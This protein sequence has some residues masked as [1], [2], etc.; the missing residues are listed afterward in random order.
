M[1]Y[2]TGWD[3]LGRGKSIAY[4]LQQARLPIADYENCKNGKLLSIIMFIIF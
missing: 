4:K 3:R 1:C 2:L